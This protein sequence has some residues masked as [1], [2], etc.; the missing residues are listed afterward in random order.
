MKQVHTF[1][2][3]AVKTTFTLRM[4]DANAKEA[5]GVAKECFEHLE[6]L[7]NKLNRYL[8]GSDV[9]QINHMQAGERDPLERVSVHCV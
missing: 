2:H 4:C 7:E 3:D 8:E 6:Y 5:A 9:W 1:S